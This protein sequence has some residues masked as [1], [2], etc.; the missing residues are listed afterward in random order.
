MANVTGLGTTYNLP[1]YSGELFQLGLS[2][3]PFLNLIGGINGANARKVQSTSF[4]LNQNWKTNE[5]SQPAISE[6]AAA[7]GKEATAYKRAQETN[8]VQI[9]QEAINITYSKMGNANALD[10]INVNGEPIM[11]QNELDFQIAAHLKQIALDANYTFLKGAYTAPT[12][13]ST[14]VK[15]RGI[16]TAI[17]TKVVEN[18]SETELTKGMVD[19]LIRNAA[20]DGFDFTNA[21]VMVDAYNKQLLTKIFGLAPQDRTIGGMN[22]NQIETDFGRVMVVFEP[23]MKGTLGLFDMN[24][25][26][27]VLREIPTKGIGV[28]YEPLA[29][30]GASEKGQLYG[31]LGL[32]Y[33]S[34]SFHGKITNLTTAPATT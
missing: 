7:D 10:G 8:V 22:I 31:E 23:L 6:K 11:Q 30:T 13:E 18:S 24:K 17:T 2:T 9:F 29:K 16:M 5:P 20:T 33:G 26:R 3:T 32:D 19:E 4:A 34:E 21:V 25:I 1:N 27:P 15:S 28:F 12:D 14:A